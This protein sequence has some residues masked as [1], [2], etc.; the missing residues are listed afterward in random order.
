MKHQI[1]LQQL[2]KDLEI[3]RASLA[4]WEGHPPIELGGFSHEVRAGQIDVLK[5]VV[6]QTEQDIWFLEQDS[7]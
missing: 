1:P 3:L 6:A 4:F 5:A 7:A 2:R